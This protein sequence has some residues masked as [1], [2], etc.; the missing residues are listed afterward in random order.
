MTTTFVIIVIIIMIIIIIKNNE[1]SRLPNKLF[2]KKI[3]K[4]YQFSLIFGVI[5][6]DEITNIQYKDSLELTW[7]R[8]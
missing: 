2:D 4:F 6:N 8:T 7:Q 1:I 5:I 3:H